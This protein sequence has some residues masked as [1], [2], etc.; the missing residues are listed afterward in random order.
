MENIDI[1]IREM[2]DKTSRA[3]NIT[4]VKKVSWWA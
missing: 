1:I 2:E 3:K 4:E